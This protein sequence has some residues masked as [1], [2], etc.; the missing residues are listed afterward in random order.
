M[1]D[2]LKTVVFS[3]EEEIAEQ[4]KEFYED[5]CGF[6]DTSESANEAESYDP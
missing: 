3:F 1:N 2:D 6:D 5:D 4:S